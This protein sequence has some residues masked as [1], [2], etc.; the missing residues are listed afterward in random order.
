MQRLPVTGRRFRA[1]DPVGE[2]VLL[3]LDRRELAVDG[4]D[5]L[6]VAA[7]GTRRAEGLS[8]HGNPHQVGVVAATTRGPLPGCPVWTREGPPGRT[9]RPFGGPL[10]QLGEGLLP[11]ALVAGLAGHVHLG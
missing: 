9:R 3:V 5:H 7:F 11:G 10:R 4:F 1:G 2:T 8:Q 6:E